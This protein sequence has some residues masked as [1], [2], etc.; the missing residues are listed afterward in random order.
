MVDLIITADTSL[1]PGNIVLK[2]IK[3]NINNNKLFKGL[4]LNFLCYNSC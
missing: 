4:K 2:L 3:I 1:F